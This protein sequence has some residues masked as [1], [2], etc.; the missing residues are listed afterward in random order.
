MPL[1]RHGINRSAQNGPLARISF[2]ET[3]D[4]INEAAIFNMSDTGRGVTQSVMTGQLARMGTGLFGVRV[5]S[6]EAVS[7][8]KKKKQ[9]CKSRI[10][11]RSVHASDLDESDA[12]MF[13][14]VVDDRNHEQYTG[15]EC[16]RPFET[17]IAG[18]NDRQTKYG[19]PPRNHNDSYVPPTPPRRYDVLI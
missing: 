2:E 11:S 18:G 6:D 16:Q 4:L 14:N 12:N 5:Q 19:S 3:V 1:T 10:H 7:N 9:L 8:G 15:Q 17:S 13:R